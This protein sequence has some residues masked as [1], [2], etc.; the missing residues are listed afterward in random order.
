MITGRAFLGS[1]SPFKKE[2]A[3]PAAPYYGFIFFE[4]CSVIDIRF[5]IQVAFF[6]L[7]LCNG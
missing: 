7:F 6:M 1:G 2:T 4:D 3:V 5:K